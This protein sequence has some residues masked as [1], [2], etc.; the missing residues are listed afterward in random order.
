MAE[1]SRGRKVAAA[2]AMAVTAGLVAYEAV[3]HFRTEWLLLAAAGGLAAAGLG[4]T[5]RSVVAQVVSR[6]LAWAV[7]AP[8]LM[9]SAISLAQG[10]TAPVEIT[11]LG[12]STAAALLLSRPML[13]TAAAHEAFAPRVF[14]RI[15]LAGSTASVMAA[16]YAAFYALESFQFFHRIGPAIAVS[17]LAASLLAS[18]IGVVKMRGWAIV[19]GSVT[20]LAGMVAAMFL[21]SGAGIGVLLA[22]APF[23]A[24]HLVPVLLARYAPDPESAVRVGASDD[25]RD[26]DALARARVRVAVDPDDASVLDDVPAAGARRAAAIPSD[27]R[28]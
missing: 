10:A 4:M 22:V 6:G 21:G 23:L 8:T 16:A 24:L 11:L 20:S 2:G 25:A 5:R 28:T 1:I 27:A 17:A 9:L 13:H 3:S 7:L 14:R 12:A 18:A 19:L 26:A 15:F